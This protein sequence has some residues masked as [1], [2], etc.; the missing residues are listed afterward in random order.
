[1]HNRYDSIS[2]DVAWFSGRRGRRS[3]YH[4]PG[5]YTSDY[6]DSRSAFRVSELTLDTFIVR[7]CHVTCTY[8]YNSLFHS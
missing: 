5:M 3:V 7:H 8:M 6:Y 4:Y 1:M 2:D